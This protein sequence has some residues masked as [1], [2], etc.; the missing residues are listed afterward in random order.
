MELI[1]LIWIWILIGVVMW[2][3]N[4]SI[5]AECKAKLYASK[6][7]LLRYA[8]ETDLGETTQRNE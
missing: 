3:R 7:E 4:K 1:G 5:K 8:Q 2:Y 6:Y